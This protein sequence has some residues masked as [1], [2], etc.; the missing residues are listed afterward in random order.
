MIKELINFIAER[1]AIRRRRE[2]GQPFPW[3]DNPILR[4]YRFCNIDREHDR[5]TKGI[6][7]LYREPYRD[8]PNL[9]FAL[10]VSRRAVNW[11]GTLAE[12]GYPVPWNPER[13]KDVIRS[14]QASGQKAYEAQAYKVMVSGQAGEQADLI[15]RRVL[16]PMWEQ[17]SYYQPRTGDTLASFATR[18]SEGPFMGGFYAGQIIADLKYVQLRD[19]ADWWTFA[20]SGP[21]SRRGLDRVMGRE[22][23]KYW[24][25]TAWYAEFRQLYES[26]K[27][28]IHEV[29]GL[30]LDA[31]NEQ[32]ALCEFDKFCRLDNGEGARSVRRYLSPS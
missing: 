30:C 25:E 13:F 10:L 23:R 6:T 14:R 17:R 4:D 19:A 8:D 21:G 16:T 31:Q 20:V 24:S 15:T 18:L 9:W 11:P 5:V 29:T 1:E 12:L 27:Q 32:N 22:P 3:T 26:T 2:A 7:A 28:R